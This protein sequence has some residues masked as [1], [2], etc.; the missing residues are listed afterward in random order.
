MAEET[1]VDDTLINKTLYQELGRIATRIA[2]QASSANS[3]RKANFTLS[4]TFLNHAQGLVG[5]DNV[6]ARRLLNHARRL[7][8][9]KVRDE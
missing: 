4:M 6:R 1:I 9:I 2:A 5:I 7:S 3:E 8:N